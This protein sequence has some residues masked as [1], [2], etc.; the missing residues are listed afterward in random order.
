MRRTNYRLTT[1]RETGQ[2]TR[3][4][5]RV[6]TINV[7]T[8]REKE[9]E[10]MGVMKERKLEVLGLCETRTKGRVEKVIHDN[11]KVICS[12]NERGSSGVG[13]I[14]TPDLVD[15]IENIN[16]KNE[17]ILSVTIKFEERK[18]KFMQVY[19]PQQGRTTAE[20]EVFYEELKQ[21]YEGGDEEKIIMGDWNGHVGIDREGVEQVIGAFSI[22]NKNAEGERVIDLCVSN[23]LAIMNTFYKHQ[24]S[25]KWTWYRFNND[26][27]EYTDK[28]MI[29]LFA[30]NNKTLFKDVKAIPSLSCDSDHRLVVA[31]LQLTTPKTRASKQQTRYRLENLKD[32]ECKDRVRYGIR[33][34]VPAREELN[35]MEES[36]KEFKPKDGF[37]EVADREVG[38]KTSKRTKKKITSW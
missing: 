15:R 23:H 13:M 26:R 35:N 9:H 12:G 18:I 27:D 17:R 21:V 37:K 14:I 2:R 31:N 5:F 36:W 32:Q 3:K 28:S 1:R 4:S 11:F 8:L 16:F 6:A 24:A 22:G 29:D 20:K 19:V 7:G 38:T 30:T 10:L 33:E 34:K 25:Q